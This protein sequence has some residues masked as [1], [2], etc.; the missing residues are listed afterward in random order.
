VSLNNLIT[1][2]TTNDERNELEN[3]EIIRSTQNALSDE[4]MQ[5]CNFI[6]QK[7]FEFSHRYTEQNIK[8]FSSTFSKTIFQ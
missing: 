3:E 7:K 8:L 6:L 2:P 5:Q 1:R 4:R